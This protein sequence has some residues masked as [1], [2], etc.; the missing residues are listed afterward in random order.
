MKKKKRKDEEKDTINRY[1]GIEF[2]HRQ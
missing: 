2:L 1:E